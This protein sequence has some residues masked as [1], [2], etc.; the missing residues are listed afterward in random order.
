MVSMPLTSR[1]LPDSAMGDRRENLS[2]AGG[3]TQKLFE[4]SSWL[5]LTEELDSYILL[6]C[7]EKGRKPKQFRALSHNL[8]K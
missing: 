4:Q 7:S 8:E 2:I 1:I 3:T 5:L 6:V